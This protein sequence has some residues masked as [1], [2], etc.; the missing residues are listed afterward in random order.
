MN[1][2][3]FSDMLCDVELMADDNYALV[4][5]GYDAKGNWTLYND[6]VPIDPDQGSGSRLYAPSCSF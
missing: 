6:H 1:M 3:S 5:F 2:P 4:A